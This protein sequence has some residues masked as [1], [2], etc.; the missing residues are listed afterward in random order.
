MNAYELLCVHAGSGDEAIKA[1]YRLLARTYHPDRGGDP[2]KFTELPIA[3]KQI[4]DAKARAQY[5]SWL[6]LHGQ[7]CSTCGGNGYRTKTKSFTQQ[8]RIGCGSC[9]GCGYLVT[10]HGR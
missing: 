5:R 4:A 1:S 8:V 10:T 6:A 9:G 7:L 3:Y 2:A